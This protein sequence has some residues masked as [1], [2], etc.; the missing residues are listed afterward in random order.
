MA[1]FA[2][3]MTMGFTA[4]SD[5]DD[6][7]DPGL[8]VP[9]AQERPAISTD[10]TDEVKVGVDE[11]A[12]FNITDGGGNYKVVAE[13]PEY[14]TAEIN[15]S[16]ITLKGLKKG[17]AGVMISDAQGNYK[18][19]TVKC[20]YFDMTLDK[21]EVSVGMKLG[22]TDGVAKVNVLQGNGQYICESADENVATATANG[23]V[24]TVQGVNSGET[25]IT[26]TD[27]MG[28]TKTINVKVQTT[29]IPFT[30][31]E[32]AAVLA[33]NEN[34]MVFEGEEALYVE[35]GGVYEL[36]Q[37]DG[38]V[39][40]RSYYSWY[41]SYD[42]IMKFKGDLSVG[43]KTDGTYVNNNAWGGMADKSGIDYE[44]LK[45]DGSR[46]WGIVSVI[47]EGYLYTGYFCMPIN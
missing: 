24:I 14:V 17:I 36:T 28:L 29:T 27:Q 6:V 18:H 21:S 43:K 45:N 11:T 46:V 33:L 19:I 25:T 47:A 37:E 7:Y 38:F 12:T 22:H 15:G 42:M 16:A 41:P 10:A 3:A 9:A 35:Y 32:K 26:V 4:C 13:N 30:E 23:E 44:I 31:E 39:T 2:M 40:M 20:M 34:K 5:D 8:N 1:L